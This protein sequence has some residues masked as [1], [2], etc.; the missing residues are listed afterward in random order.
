LEAYSAN[1][2]VVDVALA[3]LTLHGRLR[4]AIGSDGGEPVGIGGVIGASK[5]ESYLNRF[6][7]S[8]C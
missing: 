3:Q 2:E 7:Y 4:T 1:I 5:G 8:R 6:R